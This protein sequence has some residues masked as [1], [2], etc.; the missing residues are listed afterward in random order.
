MS[1]VSNITQKDVN[2][3]AL[4]L[5][6]K[7]SLPSINLVQAE[8]KRT[9]G[10]SGGSVVITRFLQ[11]WKLET[12]NLLTAKE[13]PSLPSNLSA[14]AENLIKFAMDGAEN[15]FLKEKKIISEI[16][17]TERAAFQSDK[18]NLIER[19]QNSENKL[20]ENSKFLEARIL[21]IENLNFR[22]EQDNL[23]LDRIEK[24]HAELIKKNNE[25]RHE[26]DLQKARTELAIISK[27]KEHQAKVHEIE[28]QKDKLLLDQSQSHA[29]KVEFLK[30]TH[31]AEI[32]KERESSAKEKKRLYL[33]LDAVRQQLLTLQNA[34]SEKT[35]FL[36]EKLRKLEESSIRLEIDLQNE[37]QNKILLSGVNDVLSGQIEMLKKIIE[38]R[39]G[40]I[41]TKTSTL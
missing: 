16:L 36:N 37:R 13:Q 30:A 6:S 20:A 4:N 12:A 33:E 29:N 24:E 21:E 19:L 5:L 9:I 22:S 23:L 17:E 34:T 26:F 41:E 25:L 18:N 1:K 10:Y 40:R 7:G 27:E 11:N 35:N 28:S 39:F 3:I 8:L 31:K 32:E 14:I 15:E 38:E 2:E